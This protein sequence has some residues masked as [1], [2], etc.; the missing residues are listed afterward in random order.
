MIYVIACFAP[1]ITQLL[2]VYV[3]SMMVGVIEEAS[4]RKLLYSLGIAVAIQLLSGGLF[5]AS[6]MMRIGYMRDILLDVRKN[7]FAAT[8]SKSYKSFSKQSKEVYISNLTNDIHLIESKFFLSLLNIIF[9]GGLYVAGGVILCILDI[10]LGVVLVLISLGL[11]GTSRFFANKTIR[12]QESFS[13]SNENFMLHMSNTFN[14]LE[15]LKLNQI[16]DKFLEQNLKKLDHVEKN[17]FAFNMYTDLQKYILMFTGYVVVVGVMAYVGIGIVNGMTLTKAMALVMLANNM[18]FPLMDVFP[19]INIVKSAAKIYQKTTQTEEQVEEMHTQNLFDLKEAIVAE[20]V[21]FSYGEQ[22]ILKQA[23]FTLE[24]GKKYLL[25]GVSGA[26]K[27]T[28]L[29]LLGKVYDDYE[30]SI[31]VDGVEYNQIDEDS[32]FQKSAVIYQDVFLF[33]DSIRNNITLYQ[34]ISEEKLESAIKGAGLKA[35]LSERDLDEKL[36]ENGKNLSGG[37]RQRL[38]I[39]RAIAK[40]AQILLIDEGTSSLNPELGREV[41]EAFLGL[42]HTIVAISHRYYEGVSE[43]YDYVL[44]LKNGKINTYPAN[45]YY[46]EARVC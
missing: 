30:G 2:Q 33:E 32:F 25:K 42:D 39:A 7:I 5:L 3:M 4:I 45:E 11:L 9:K 43:R 37:Q 40:N 31:K 41:E 20:N 23:S 38:S 16:E 22:Q 18:Y 21:S 12:L 27:S 36:L 29:K 35:W 1:V 28:L 6:R 19:L 17:K 14:G 34:D 10:K 44:E 24:K 15:I 8:L 13:T 46:G 26:G